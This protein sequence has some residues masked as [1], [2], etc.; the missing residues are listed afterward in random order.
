MNQTLPPPQPPPHSQSNPIDLT[1][2][3]DNDSYTRCDR[4]PKRVC[5][6]SRAFNA[7][8]DVAHSLGHLRV[9]PHHSGLSPAMSS[10]SLQPEHH[11]SSYPISQSSSS[12]SPLSQSINTTLRPAFTGPSN[13]SAFFPRA[14]SIQAGLPT[15]LAPQAQLDSHSLRTAQAQVAQGSQPSQAHPPNASRQVI[16]LTS[17]PSPPPT[18]QPPSQQAILQAQ[19]PHPAPQPSLPDD[20]P[21]KTPVCIGQLTVT[22]LVLYPLP[23]LQPQ[24]GPNSPEAEWAPVRMNYE[25]NASKPDNRDTIHIRTPNMTRPDGQLIPGEN[26]GVVEQKVAN[27]LGPMLGKGLI[28]L[29][30]KVRRGP[31]NVMS[32]SLFAIMFQ[33]TPY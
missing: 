11:S 1:G 30:G 29:D 25:H 24:Y 12:I 23:Y 27:F 18:G 28:R 15:L 21:P 6:E 5:S 33:L 10:S 4:K 20:L 31:P 22:A 2:D 19:S 32:L 17:S 3:D 9:Q 16:D 7:A 14:P 26:F 8:N 13:S